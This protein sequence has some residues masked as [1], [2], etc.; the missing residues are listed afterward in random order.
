MTPT[1]SPILFEYGCVGKWVDNDDCEFCTTT[2]TKGEYGES[3]CVKIKEYNVVPV[4]TYISYNDCFN[5]SLT[6]TGWTQV[7]EEDIVEP[8]IYSTDFLSKIDNP[9]DIR[10]AMTMRT[11]WPGGLDDS[12]KEIFINEFFSGKDVVASGRNLHDLRLENT[13]LC[14]W[15]SSNKDCKRDIEEYVERERNGE[16]NNTIGSA[17]SD[18]GDCEFSRN[19]RRSTSDDIIEM[20]KC[21]YSECSSKCNGNWS[22]WSNCSK[23]C[24]NERTSSNGYGLQQRSFLLTGDGSIENCLINDIDWN[25]GWWNGFDGTNYSI[26]YNEYDNN[27]LTGNSLNEY[28]NMNDNINGIKVDKSNRYTLEEA[29]R[30]CSG[31]SNCG[32]FSIDLRGLSMEEF[33]R[34][35]LKAVMGFKER[36]ELYKVKNK[37]DFLSYKKKDEILWNGVEHGKLSNFNIGEDH[38]TQTRN[39]NLGCSVN[40]EQGWVDGECEITTDTKVLI[41]NDDPPERQICT[42]NN[43]EM[44]TM[45]SKWM[46]IQEPVGLGDDCGEVYS[47][48]I[49][50]VTEVPCIIETP[51]PV[52]GSLLGDGSTW[53]LVGGGR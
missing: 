29:M 3:P 1:P 8:C 47:D 17:G 38:I 22:E 12:S 30:L 41:S 5:Y 27:V 23:K 50:L 26:L 43:I 51:L 21:S 42:D 10:D 14:H 15:I 53:R 9:E 37:A 45:K 49:P 34:G 35:D 28:I 13:G 16:R 52:C 39:C 18:F 32:G 6:S 24:D 20:D 25:K 48:T 44:G 7:E 40:C 46:K 33:K 31:I 2:C 19:V 4:D 36:Q 11:S